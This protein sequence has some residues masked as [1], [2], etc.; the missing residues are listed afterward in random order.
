VDCKRCVARPV[1]GGVVRKF[2]QDL[3][4]NPFFWLSFAIVVVIRLIL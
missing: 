4:N 2:L 3:W 1:V